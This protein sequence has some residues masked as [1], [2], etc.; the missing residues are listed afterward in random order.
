MIPDDEVIYI[1]GLMRCCTETL[2]ARI[3]A[4]R[5]HERQQCQHCTSGAVFTEGV[6]P[7]YPAARGS[8]R[9]DRS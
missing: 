8:W 1:G 2:Y 9:W 7:G 6:V 3:R 4:A 5:N